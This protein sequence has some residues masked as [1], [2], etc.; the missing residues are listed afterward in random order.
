[1]PATDGGNPRSTTVVGLELDVRAWCGDPYGTDGVGD[2]LDL[3]VCHGERECVDME[4]GEIFSTEIEIEIQPE[5]RERNGFPSAKESS[6]LDLSA[7]RMSME[8]ASLR[9]FFLI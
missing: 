1:M 2:D 9:G 3:E 5:R 4:M 6:P 8:T 7:V